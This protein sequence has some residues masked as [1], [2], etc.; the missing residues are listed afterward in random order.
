M[1][2][3]YRENTNMKKILAVALVS[4]ALSACGDDEQSKMNNLGNSSYS[5]FEN[6]MLKCSV[7][8]LQALSEN[9]DVDANELAQLKKGMQN[10][11]K[12]K[13]SIMCLW[14]RSRTFS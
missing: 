10:L 7:K 4:L 2:L 14:Y 9:K 1:N 12:A 5:D 8:N 6:Q 13:E 11:P 3:K